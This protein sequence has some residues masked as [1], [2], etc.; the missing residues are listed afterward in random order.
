MCVWV[1]FVIIMAPLCNM[2][3]GTRKCVCA[4]MWVGGCAGSRI[5]TIPPVDLFRFHVTW[6]VGNLLCFG[7]FPLITTCPP[8]LFLPSFF[9]LLLPFLHPFFFLSTLSF[10]T[11]TT[12]TGFL[13]TPVAPVTVYSPL[14]SPLT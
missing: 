2:G 5:F 1:R 6:W 10:T 14:F 7:S 8:L 13:N 9:S 12:H 11:T 4:C 3:G